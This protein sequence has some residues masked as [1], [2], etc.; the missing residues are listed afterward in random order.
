MSLLLDGDI[1]SG[2]ADFHPSLNG[3]CHEP[4]CLW[5]PECIL[6]E[7]AVGP[8]QPVLALNPCAPVSCGPMNAALGACLIGPLLVSP[9]PEFQWLLGAR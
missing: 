2:L 4:C 5:G 9:W 8:V 3:S 7:A 6:A 1:S